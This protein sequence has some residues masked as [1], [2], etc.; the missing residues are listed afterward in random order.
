MLQQSNEMSLYQRGNSMKSRD[1]L[2]QKQKQL[3]SF[4]S[5]QAPPGLKKGREVSFSGMESDSSHFLKQW[6]MAIAN[7]SKRDSYKS[8]KKLTDK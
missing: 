2:Q 6:Q 5:R 8:L 7:Q 4:D 1:K 3:S